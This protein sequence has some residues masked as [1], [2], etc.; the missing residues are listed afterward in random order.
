MNFDFMKVKADK[1]EN[2]GVELNILKFKNSSLF[3]KQK[4]SCI[5]HYFDRPRRACLI[6]N[7]TFK[8]Y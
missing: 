5:C 6:E 4:I 1:I 2:N 7:D 8:M 3:S